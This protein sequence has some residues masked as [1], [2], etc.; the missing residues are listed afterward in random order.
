MDHRE[1]LAAT[2]LEYRDL[3][4]D[5][6]G[7]TDCC[8][9][10]AT[11]CRHRGAEI[12]MPD[13]CSQQEAF[14]LMARGFPVL[15]D[16]ALGEHL[17]I[18]VEEAKIGDIVVIGGDEAAYPGIHAGTSAFVFRQPPEEVIEN[19]ARNGHAPSAVQ[20]DPLDWVIAAWRL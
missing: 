2:V 13:Y 16:Y 20:R 5:W 17:R 8:Q 4:P 1:A 12:R 18:D 10:A 11:Y 15:I 14:R 7:E 9:F 6:L 3:T 19:A